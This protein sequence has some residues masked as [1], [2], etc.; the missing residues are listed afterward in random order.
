MELFE[1]HKAQDHE[2][3]GAL[4][5]VVTRSEQGEIMLV[6]ATTGITKQ[7]MYCLIPLMGLPKGCIPLHESIQELME[8]YPER[9]F[10]EYESLDDLIRWM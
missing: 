7:P 2:H 6:E 3:F 8:Y 4:P 10:F 5:Q 1:L 9:L